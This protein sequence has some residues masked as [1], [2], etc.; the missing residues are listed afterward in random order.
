MQEG[1]VWAS[2]WMW[3]AGS[4]VVHGA[5]RASC[6]GTSAFQAFPRP[7]PRAAASIVWHEALTFWQE[8]DDAVHRFIL[9]AQEVE[10]E[11]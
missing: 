10:P 2:S 1:G 9:L 8:V 5:Q 4:R 11:C 7:R 3:R 6:Q